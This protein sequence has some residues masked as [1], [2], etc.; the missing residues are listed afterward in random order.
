MSDDE[1]EEME[2]LFLM[3]FL[4]CMAVAGFIVAWFKLDV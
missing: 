1:G 3:C 2:T 4:I